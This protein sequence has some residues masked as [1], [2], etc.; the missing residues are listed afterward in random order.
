MTVDEAYERIL[1]LRQLTEATGFITKRSQNELLATLP[2]DVLAEVALRLQQK[3]IKG[4][5]HERIRH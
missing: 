5:D 2:S 4:N 1:A 3:S